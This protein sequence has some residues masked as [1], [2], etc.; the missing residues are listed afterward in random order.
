MCLSGTDRASETQLVP[1]YRTAFRAAKGGNSE[2]YLGH[3]TLILFK[4]LMQ[5]AKLVPSEAE[6]GLRDASFKSWIVAVRR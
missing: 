5:I 1:T 3:V 4:A 2:T 6:P